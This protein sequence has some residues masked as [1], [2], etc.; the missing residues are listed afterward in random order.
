MDIV[1][2]TAGIIAGT[3]I[4]WLAANRK[5][6]AFK[7]QVEAFRQREELLKHTTE[8]RLAREK[9]M[10][11]ERYAEQEGSSMH[12]WRNNANSWI[13]AWQNNGK[14]PMHCTGV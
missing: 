7:A 8:E 11:D 3:A 12:A 13:N 2:L 1:T 6:A 10:A 5:S 14:R 4:G 9:A